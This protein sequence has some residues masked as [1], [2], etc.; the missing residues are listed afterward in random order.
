MDNILGQM[1]ENILGNISM[2]KC[3]EMEII[4]GL[5]AKNILDNGKM[6][7]SMGKE[8]FT[9]EVQQEEQ[10]FGKKEEE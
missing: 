5:M 4:F 7:N 8:P 1:E 3:M 6:V 2:T 10:A 9:I